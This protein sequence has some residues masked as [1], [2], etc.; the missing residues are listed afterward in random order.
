[1]TDETSGVS[2]GS[3]P[4][5]VSATA[6]G[7]ASLTAAMNAVLKAMKPL[8]A[9]IKAQAQSVA[10]RNAQW[11]AFKPLAVMPKKDERSLVERHVLTA[12]SAYLAWLEAYE[13]TEGHK[14]RLK[15]AEEEVSKAEAAL[16]EAVKAVAGLDELKGD[17]TLAS[18]QYMLRLL[19]GRRSQIEGEVR[20]ER[21]HVELTEEGEIPL[22]K[23]R[24]AAIDYI[25]TEV[26]VRDR[27]AAL[28]PLVTDVYLGA[29]L[30]RVPLP[31]RP[32]EEEI[33][34]YLSNLENNLQRQQEMNRRAHP[35]LK[36]RLTLVSQYEQ[37]DQA[38]NDALAAAESDDN[39]H[40][41]ALVPYVWALKKI[42]EIVREK[43]SKRDFAEDTDYTHKDFCRNPETL[44]IH[45]RPKS[46]RVEQDQIDY[47]R[48]QM[49]VVAFAVAHREE[50]E[51]TL[52]NFNGNE[53]KVTP[54]G[55]GNVANWS[56]CLA[57]YE[58]LRKQRDA[59]ELESLS[60]STKVDL[61]KR[62]VEHYGEQATDEMKTLYKSFKAM[63]PHNGP[64]PSNELRKLLDQAEWMCK[65]LE[66]TNHDY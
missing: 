1:M 14:R 42:I 24:S 32:L 62:N 48:K 31:V 45:D 19:G 38:W 54:S 34:R 2:Q 33:V 57:W 53:V 23:L 63:I 21:K 7:A 51:F 5:E 40:K 10:L 39:P 22:A 13:A 35:L 28:E 49:R 46:T 56:E 4:E 11:E 25:I 29:R 65:P 20:N 9:L 16:K 8:D 37:W 58:D 30:N 61:L 36:E 52:K 59:A 64:K 50:A 66:K 6:G 41:Q 18:A 60:R 12:E 26:I 43:S 27:H 15:H 3:P 17:K 44:E 47:L 55:V